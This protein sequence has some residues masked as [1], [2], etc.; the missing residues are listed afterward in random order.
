MPGLQA[1]LQGLVQSVTSQSTNV[2]EEIHDQFAALDPEGTGMASVTAVRQL[3]Q[4]DQFALSENEVE[5]L[6]RQLNLS[7][8]SS[9]KYDAW[10]AAMVSWK[11]VRSH[12][13]HLHAPR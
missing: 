13:E 6:L 11:A 12:H 9:I 3:L 2:P 7:E 4:G 10:V 5:R 8:E 1:V